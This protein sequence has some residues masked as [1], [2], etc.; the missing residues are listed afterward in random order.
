MRNDEWKMVFI[1]LLQSQQP[2][3]LVDILLVFV[4]LLS[5]FAGYRRGFIR[6]V[7]D[8]L[9]WALVLIAGLRFYQPIAR[10]IGPRVHLWSEVW[11]QP[12][13]F[14]LIAIVVIVAIQLLAYSL[15]HRLPK[16]THKET[17]NRVMGVLPG[18][19]NGLITAALI[20]ALLLAIPLNEGLRERA[21][22]SALA[23]RLA[24][25][26][27]RLEAALHP[28]FAEAVAETLNLLTVQPES[29]E[30]VNLPFKVANGRA[31]PELEA[32]ML[33]LV[34]RE[35]TS[36]GLKPLAP[37]PELT[38]VARS[39]SGDMFAR[40]YF[41]HDTPEGRSPFDRI[42]EA[43]VRF[44][45]AGENLALAPSVLVAHNGLMNS[46]GHRANILQPSFGRL[47]IGI[48]DGGIRGIMVT[49]NFRN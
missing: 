42:K 27:E 39:H 5:A 17:F 43:N 3:N 8:L 6:G 44:Q 13:A 45:T 4:V 20:A 35:R 24:V 14:V 16:D 48:L 31:R 49:Q 22:E 28:V 46:P 25:Y 36:R 38:Q 40:G 1:L 26:A 19:A 34:N 7:L 9:G 29:H 11:D 10:W 33:D 15:L 37:D 41:A 32:R 30:R 12:V 23:N 2:V 47:G 18:L 21:R